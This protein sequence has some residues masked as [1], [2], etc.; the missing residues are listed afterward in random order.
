MSRI[1]EDS[2]AS[3][4]GEDFSASEDDWVPGK[5][6]DSTDSDDEDVFDDESFEK[7]ATE[8]TGRRKT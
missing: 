7:S 5:E 4:S 6:K 3:E 1:F 2:D 8:V